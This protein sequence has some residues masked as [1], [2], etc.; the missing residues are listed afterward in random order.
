MRTKQEI[1]TE[2][3]DRSGL[4]SAQ[5]FF[6]V[7][8]GGA[9]M[10]GIARLLLD[11]GCRVKGSDSTASPLT[12]ELAR[13]GVDVHIGHTGKGLDPGDA[14]VLSDAIDL[15]TS[16]ELARAKELG[17]PVYRRSQAL[18]W[19]LQGLKVVAV[20]GTHGK[21]TTTGMVA[22]GMRAAGMDPTVVVGAEVPE[23]GSSVVVGKD[24]WAVVEACEAYDSFH[25]LDPHIV[26]LTNL[27]LDHVDFHEN[28]QNLLASVVRFV[29][30]IPLGGTLVHSDQKGAAE[31]GALLGRNQKEYDVTTF[32]RMAPGLTLSSPGVHNRANAGGALLACVEAGA[33]VAKAAEG[34]AK[35]HGAKRRLQVVATVKLAGQGDEAGVTVV[36]DYAHH[37]TEIAASVAALREKFPGRRLLVVFQPHL[38][39]RTKDQYDAFAQAL[40]AAD[41]AVVTDIYPA[42]EE[43]LP[44]VSAL[45]VVEALTC[46]FAY[47]PCRHLLPREVRKLALPGDVVVGMGA[48]NIEEFVPAFIS[49]AARGPVRR[50]AVVA[51]GDSPEREVS[52]HSGRAVLGAL[53][54]LGY[55]AYLV[56][57]ADLLL[58]RGDLS[59][60]TGNDRPD[61]CFL[62]V[63]G[64]RS[65][66]GALQGLLECAHLPYT[67][68]GVLANALAMD[69]DMT[70]QVLA[71]AGVPVAKGV[72][73]RAGDPLP[74][75]PAPL[76]VKPNA[77]GST[78][79]LT[80]VKRDGEL[81]GAVE[82]ALAYGDEVLVEEFLEGVEI[83][84][85]CLGGRVLAPIEVVPG[86]GEYD[87]ATKYTPGEATKHCPARISEADT[88][89]A[90]DYAVRAVK[91]LGCRGVTRTDMIV[92]A[93]GPVALEVNTLPGM[94][95]TS[96]VAIS[97]QNAG[98]TFDDLVEWM[99]CDAA[100]QEV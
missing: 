5:A 1:E 32:G 84:V 95:S 43:P 14:L 97:A 92:T 50:V 45:R 11:K 83:T 13:E 87:F 68:S 65:E 77:Q 42:R 44:G 86:S 20:T 39:S 79:G 24:P 71:R 74:E 46:P 51:G 76:V 100:R 78:V 73:L 25:D 23:F 31:V 40:S 60:L 22:A 90:Q 27:E 85:P 82:K 15:H 18:G 96:L 30:T 35:F 56:D 54:R 47:V 67:G 94:T 2:F 62:A 4:D 28:Y 3:R 63:H 36:D 29:K 75:W 49:E 66:D 21:T 19:L 48:G 17:V 9:G 93:R 53:E 41:L 57:V 69:K 98:M 99:V 34:I 61:V 89:S 33:D 38:Y 91:A 16:P 8:V 64:V 58:G 6:L 55:D 70:K 26:V 72:L 59:K 7:G 12:D 81:A 88:K 37:P 52:L 10:S 80:F